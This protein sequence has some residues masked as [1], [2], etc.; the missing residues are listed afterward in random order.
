[1]SN[2]KITLGGGVSDGTEPGALN[3]KPMYNLS[4]VGDGAGCR[5]KNSHAIEYHSPELPNVDKGP[6][7]TVGCGMV[8]VNGLSDWWQTTLVTEILEDTPDYMKFKTENSIYE[9]RHIPDTEG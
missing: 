5:G 4:R 9:W 3:Y 6:R 8:V 1:M 2:N 7:P